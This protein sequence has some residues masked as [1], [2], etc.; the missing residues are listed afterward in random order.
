[1]IYMHL[2]LIWNI[3]PHFFLIFLLPDWRGLIISY[4][5]HLCRLT[6]SPLELAHVSLFPYLFTQLS[7][8]GAYR[9]PL[10]CFRFS[11]S[12]YNLRGSFIKHSVSLIGRIKL[13]F[14]NQ[15]APLSCC[16]RCSSSFFFLEGIDFPSKHNVA[17]LYWSL[18]LSVL[19]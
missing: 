18:P 8:H 12:S 5:G 14:V 10:A 9:C 17:P 1:M 11:V 19:C 13:P 3:G 2:Y 15:N 6:S 4:L 7:L 16:R